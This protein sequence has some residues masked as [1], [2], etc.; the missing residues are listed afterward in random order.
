MIKKVWA[1]YFSGTGTTEKV[2]KTLADGISKELGCESNIFNFTFPKN[3]TDIKEFSQTDLVVFG[4]PA[5]VGVPKTT[6]R[7][8]LFSVLPHMLEGF[9]TCL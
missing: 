5:Y 2:V 4:T 9:L 8:W 1:M 6:K 3:R 7:I